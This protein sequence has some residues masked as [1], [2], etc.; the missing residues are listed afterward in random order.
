MKKT[1]FLF[2]LIATLA[3]GCDAGYSRSSAG[4][5]GF[6]NALSVIQMGVPYI[7]GMDLRLDS[8][9]L[10]ETDEYGRTLFYYSMGQSRMGALLIVQ[11]TADPLV[12][13]YEDDCYIVRESANTQ[14][15][16]DSE[17]ML[18][19]KERND[20]NKPLNDENM[21]SADYS[22]PA[23]HENVE[24]AREIC[25]VLRGALTRQYP[26]KT[27]ES[28]QIDLNGLED[29][30]NCGQVML[31]RVHHAN[32]SE[33][34]NY[35]V[36]YNAGNENAVIAMKPAGSIDD[37]RESIILFKETYCRS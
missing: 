8:I 21:R 20:W 9:K 29:Y 17:D 27:W 18:L 15:S 32:N 10:L 25:E 30:E 2:V 16:F 3:C 12:Y 36:L 31:V 13:Y 37:F 33:A 7:S 26:E 22:I 28:V 4:E 23:D 1:F 35:L 24:N 34:E 19:L 5:S 11:K 6:D 14:D